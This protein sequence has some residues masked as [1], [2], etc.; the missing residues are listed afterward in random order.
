MNLEAIVLDDAGKL[1][2]EARN[3]IAAK[4]HTI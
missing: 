4:P 1:A 2:P 3:E